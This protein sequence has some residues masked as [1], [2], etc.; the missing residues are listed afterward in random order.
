[1]K[2]KGE[3][4]TVGKIR[5]FSGTLCAQRSQLISSSSAAPLHPGAVLPFRAIHVRAGLAGPERIFTL[6][7][8]HIKIERSFGKMEDYRRRAEAKHKKYL[9]D[10]KAKLRGAQ[11]EFSPPSEPAD[12]VLDSEAEDE[13]AEGENGRFEAL[14]RASEGLGDPMRIKLLIPREG[15]RELRLDG[16]TKLEDIRRLFGTKSVHLISKGRRLVGDKTLRE[17]GVKDGET[18]HC[19]KASRISLDSSGPDPEETDILDQLDPTL[20]VFGIAL[21]FLGIFWGLLFTSGLKY[22]TPSSVVLLVGLTFFTVHL[23]A[24]ITSSS[25]TSQ[26]SSPST[27]S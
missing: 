4:E 2:R 16:C 13:K 23:M 20:V 27:P 15:T 14:E 10:Q 1:M 11:P 8:T 17:S 18:I 25:S 6:F 26:S 3:A 7:D 19:W 5:K 9:D 21:A 12:S 24:Q 22:F